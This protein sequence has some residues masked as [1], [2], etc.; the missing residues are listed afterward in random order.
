MIKAANPEVMVII[1]MVQI[2]IHDLFF[3]FDFGL[4]MNFYFIICYY[5]DNTHETPN[6]KS[7][8]TPYFHLR[9][10]GELEKKKNKKRGV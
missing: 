2:Y 3:I 8:K 9:G 5:S 4:N 6:Q 7:D 10:E 1:V